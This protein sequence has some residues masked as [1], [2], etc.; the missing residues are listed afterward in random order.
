MNI[1]NDDFIL[2]MSF[3]K[4]DNT[5]VIGTENS[6]GAEYHDCKTLEDLEK[7][8]TDYINNYLDIEEEI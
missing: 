1:I 3:D 2:E 5:V 8:F 7:A 4:E 6:S